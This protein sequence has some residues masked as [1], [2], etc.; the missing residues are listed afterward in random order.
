MH[1]SGGNGKMEWDNMFLKDNKP[2]LEQ[3]N[4]CVNN[5]LWDKL[6]RILIE[7]YGIS[8]KLEYSNCSMQRGWNMKYRKKGRNL[9]T[10]Y[11]QVDCFKVLVVISERNKVEA[12]FL[13]ETCGDTIKQ[14]YHNTKFLNGGKWLM[15]EVDNVLVLEDTI[16]LIELRA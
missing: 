6:N 13:I 12:E 7:T 8:P 4:K 14:L 10:T 11:P 2:T 15:I 3:I 1:E 9:C 5:P 16:R